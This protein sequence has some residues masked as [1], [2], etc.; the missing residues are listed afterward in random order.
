MSL[1]HVVGLGLATLLLMAYIGLTQVSTATNTVPSTR[2]GV[3]VLEIT[4]DD[5]KPAVCNS[6]RPVFV[7][8][9]SGRV[10]GSNDDDLIL[11]SPADDDLRGRQG[12][13]CLIG[14]AGDDHLNGGG[15]KDVCIGGPGKDTY[16]GCE[17]II[18]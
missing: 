2:A 7:V 15:G 1:R 9:G 16:Q 17:T 13:D 3:D 8:R 10:D 18:D 5:L 4:A 14:G 11:G 12:N 6:I